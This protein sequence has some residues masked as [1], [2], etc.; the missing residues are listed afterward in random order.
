MR[1]CATTR[2]IQTQARAVATKAVITRMR[3]AYRAS[4][5]NG[6]VITRPRRWTCSQSLYEPGVGNVTANDNSGPEDDASPGWPCTANVRSAETRN[7]WAGAARYGCR[8][9]TGAPD[10]VCDSANRSVALCPA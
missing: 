5:T 9:E 4:T 3:M 6:S 2:A 8:S 7:K 10:D 1:S